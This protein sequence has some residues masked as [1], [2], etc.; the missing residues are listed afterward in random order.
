MGASQQGGFLWKCL[1]LDDNPGGACEFILADGMGGIYRIAV[2]RI[3]VRNHWD[4]HRSAD[5][6]HHFQVLGHGNQ[7]GIRDA[8]GGR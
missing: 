7:A 1:V 6:T 3:D 2:A 5:R 8:V 4:S